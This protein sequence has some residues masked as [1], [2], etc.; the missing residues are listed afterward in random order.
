MSLN[1][2]VRRVLFHV[3]L[4]ATVWLV[5][6]FVVERIMPSSVAP[7]VNLPFIS[8]VVSFLLALQLS[9]ASTASR[10]NRVVSG[11]LLLFVSAAAG[12]FIWSRINEYGS[13]GIV[14]AISA[15]V[16]AGLTIFALTVESH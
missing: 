16:L 6:A 13:N 7:F 3:T 4:A 1:E 12:L 5:G 8:L 10:R 9:S 15:G 2:F 14:L 11:V